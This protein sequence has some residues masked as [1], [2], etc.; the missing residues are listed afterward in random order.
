MAESTR[1]VFAHL[2]GAS[3][4]VPA[5]V[6]TLVE[7]GRETAASRFAYGRHYL[8]RP[9]RIPVDPQS[10]PLDSSARGTAI[11]PVNGLALFGALRDATPD[12]WG[13]RVI[14]NKL[15]APPDSLPESVYLDHAGDN[16]A[17]ALDLRKAR[18]AP[19][20]PSLLPSALDLDHLLQAA[21]RIAEGEPVPVHLELIF[22]GAPSLGGARP[23][24]AILDAGRQWVAKFPARGDGFN[25]PMIERASLE[26]ARAAG[27][28]VPATRLIHLGD[29]RDVMLIA[30][31]DRGDEAAGYPRT[32][33]VS[34]LTMLGLDEHDRNASYIDLCRVIDQFGVSGEV[35][36][37]RAELFRRMVFNIL[38]TNDDDHLRNHAFLFDAARAGWRLSPLYDVV[39][40]P[41]LGSERYLALGVGLEGRTATLDN[42]LSQCEQFGLA[43]PAAATII[44]EVVAAVRPWRDFFEAK[45]ATA[46]ECD[47][48]A[49]AFRRAGDIGF[50]QVQAAAD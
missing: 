20:S 4:A 21:D 17:G 32:H 9:N 50:R 42:A 24:A 19:G 12:L 15:R 2:P 41:M 44:D 37:D 22:A 26:L 38:V 43:K 6:L 48:V 31:F 29:N 1:Y 34:A 36:A 46:K 10:L 18:D 11:A 39:P 23:K 40:R 47:K 27:I 13:R 14:E 45:G 33:M 28:R 49:S 30:R 35:Q 16:R 3:D 8:E 25:M 5:G 7:K